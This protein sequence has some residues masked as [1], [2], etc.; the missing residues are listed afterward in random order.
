MEIFLRATVNGH[1]CGVTIWNVATSNSLVA[2]KKT[3]S[4]PERYCTIMKPCPPH[5]D[6]DCLSDPW[7]SLPWLA[8]TCSSPHR[9]HVISLR[10]AEKG[11]YDERA[12]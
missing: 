8:L 12:R 2:Q 6:P 1:D 11:Y 5:Y 10:G 7:H 3:Q 4:I 9:G